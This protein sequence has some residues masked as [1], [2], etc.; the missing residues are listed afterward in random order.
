MHRDKKIFIAGHKG[1][2]GSAIMSKL[3]DEGF[4]NIIKASRDV[5]DLT[6]QSSV[7]DFFTSQKI[8][9][10]FLAAAKVGG[11]NANNLS[12]KILNKFDTTVF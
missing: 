9:Y 8:D 7:R 11:I 12:D 2:V 5:L 10:V 6:D 1:M 3:I 4:S